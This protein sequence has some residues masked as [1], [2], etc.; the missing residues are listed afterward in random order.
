MGSAEHCCKSVD[1]RFCSFGHDKDVYSFE[2]RRSPPCTNNLEYAKGT[3]ASTWITSLYTVTLTTTQIKIPHLNEEQ[4][5]QLKLDTRF[6]PLAASMITVYRAKAER[7]PPLYEGSTGN[8]AHIEMDA[9]DLNGVGSGAER[10][11]YNK[12][13]HLW[14]CKVHKHA[15]ILQVALWGSA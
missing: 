2:Q 6:P 1:I 12:I 10:D 13:C 7:A 8:Q 4:W 9:M 11:F 5:F 3:P 15:R 14:L